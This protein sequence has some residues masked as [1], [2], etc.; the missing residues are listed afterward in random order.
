MNFAGLSK[1]EKN[2]SDAGSGSGKLEKMA[3]SKAVESNK[4]NE[5][6]QK[7]EI[8]EK[9]KVDGGS[10][11]TSSEDQH[12]LCRKNNLKIMNFASTSK[13]EK[14]Q[15]DDDSGSGDCPGKLEKMASSKVVE[16][17]KIDEYEQKKEI[18]EKKKVD[19]QSGVTSAI[20]RHDTPSTSRAVARSSPGYNTK[21]KS[22]RTYVDHVTEEQKRV[23]EQGRYLM[24]LFIQERA[25][26]TPQ[27]S[28]IR[29]VCHAD[30][31]GPRPAGFSDEALSDIALTLRRIGDDLAQNVELNNV[32]EQVPIHSTKDIFVKVCFQIFRDGNLNWGRVVAVFYFA[33]R[34]IIRTLA[35]GLDNIP[36]VRDML[37]WAG[38]FIF[39]NVTQWV[40]SRGG[41]KMIK[42]WFGP[43]NRTWMMLCVASITFGLWAYFRKR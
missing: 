26:N 38:N 12:D 34:L 7:K 11:V 6:E 35:Q 19:D 9:K 40:I 25:E 20:Y 36:W 8:K 37:S 42:E 4:T 33:Y 30:R 10:G 24:N 2:Q 3:S 39:Q 18:K 23:G 27:Q 5:D 41:W 28:V 29:D 1:R 31:T 21:E 15:S 43:S 16:S 14:N 17:N 32:I 13:R 22:G